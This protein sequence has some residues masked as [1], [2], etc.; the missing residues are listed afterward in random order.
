MI[1]QIHQC[2]LPEELLSQIRFL[3]QFCRRAGLPPPVFA[4]HRC[5]GKTAAL[6]EYAE[7]SGGRQERNLST[8]NP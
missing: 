2:R 4:G 8:P 7:R 3:R 1:T 6:R 5:T